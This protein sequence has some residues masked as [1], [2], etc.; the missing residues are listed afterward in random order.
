MRLAR[1]GIETQDTSTLLIDLRDYD[2]GGKAYV[3]S[4]DWTRQSDAD[5]DTS[6]TIKTE[7]DFFITR[8]VDD[9]DLNLSKEELMQKYPVF[10]LT[11]LSTKR[12][13]EGKPIILV[14]VAR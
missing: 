11:G 7:A 3:Q 1:R 12:A 5:K 13:D 4:D 14:A 9:A 8:K 6:W 10:S 2:S